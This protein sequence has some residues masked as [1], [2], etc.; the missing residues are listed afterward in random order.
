MSDI[1]PFEIVDL[2]RK[3]STYLLPETT[4]N[5]LLTCSHL[6]EMREYIRYDEYVFLQNIR[7]QAF[8]VCFTH[9]KFRQCTQHIE[10][11]PHLTHLVIL[12]LNLSL[13][14]VITPSIKYVGIGHFEKVHMCH[15]KSFLA[16]GSAALK[17][18]YLYAPKNECFVIEEN[19]FPSHIER[20]TLANCK[21]HHYPFALKYLDCRPTLYIIFDTISGVY[22]PDNESFEQLK[23]LEELCLLSN[24]FINFMVFAHLKRVTIL[25][26]CGRID[27]PSSVE[28]LR[29]NNLRDN[30][31]LI[32]TLQL[33]ELHISTAHHRW[34]K[35]LQHLTVTNHDTT[36]KV[37]FELQY[38]KCKGPIMFEKRIYALQEMHI[39][40][41]DSETLDLQYFPH[42]KI[43]QIKY[44][45][46][47]INAPQILNMKSSN[48]ESL[49]M[50]LYLHQKL[51]YSATLTSLIITQWHHYDLMIP[52]GLCQLIIMNQKLIREENNVQYYQ[53]N[54]GI[55]TLTFL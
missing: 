16:T 9:I 23:N 18:I 7:F 40:L 6:Y 25:H 38:L 50:P 8:N 51:D 55:K 34:P 3:I 42:L 46:N 1:C 41:H 54:K 47:M 14:N 15:L 13:P 4:I 36:F 20:L 24:R 22:D 30:D 2:L 37:P 52:R 45:S 10:H 33:Q 27:L 43:L 26:C 44:A 53:D 11:F 31:H 28:Y 49:K 48:I 29:I 19:I 17:E 12:N 39:V 5:L 32:D 21:S 35:S